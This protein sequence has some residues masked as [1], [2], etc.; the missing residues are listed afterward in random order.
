MVCCFSALIKYVECGFPENIPQSGDSMVCF[1]EWQTACKVGD[2]LTFQAGDYLPA[3]SNWLVTSSFPSREGFFHLPGI[4][5]GH[6]RWAIRLG[7]ISH[8]LS[9]SHV[10]WL[11]RLAL[12]KTDKGPL[13]LGSVWKD[14]LSVLLVLSSVPLLIFFRLRPFPLPI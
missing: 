4:I 10:C 3:M 9:S 1:V 5:S 8:A 2:L 7:S 13:A 12:L 6:E 11:S 14:F